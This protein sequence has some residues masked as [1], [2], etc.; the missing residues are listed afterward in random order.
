MTVEP[1]ERL[2]SRAGV[3][4]AAIRPLS[5][6]AIRS[7][8]RCASS[9]KWVTSRTVTPLRADVLDELPGVAAGAR[10]E[11]GG[12]LVEDDDPGVADQRERDEQALL[13]AAGELAEPGGQLGG[14]AEAFGE[15]APVGRVRVEGG[16]QLQRLADGELG[17]QL[18]LLELGAEDA[19]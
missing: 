13:L 8:S 17:L 1:A 14:Q 11:P 2:I 6:T 12:Q 4:R 15:R 10:V 19:G 16:V 3:S 9:M 5:I 7:H 18:A